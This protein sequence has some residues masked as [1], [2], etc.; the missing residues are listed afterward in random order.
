MC[1][2]GVVY[3]NVAVVLIYIVYHASEL[4]FCRTVYAMLFRALLLIASCF[5]AKL[6]LLKTL[7]CSL[8]FWYFCQVGTRP[9]C[10]M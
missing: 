9:T 8:N 2:I 10:H 7:H 5:E 4:Y 3:D 6:C 1:S